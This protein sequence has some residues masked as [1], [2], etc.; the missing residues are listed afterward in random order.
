MGSPLLRKDFDGAHDLRMRALIQVAKLRR[1]LPQKL[2]RRGLSII[3]RY[4]TLVLS[5]CFDY[6]IRF[7]EG[8]RIPLLLLAILI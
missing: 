4:Q 1:R 3:L 2:R 6:I 7:V 5:P 8:C